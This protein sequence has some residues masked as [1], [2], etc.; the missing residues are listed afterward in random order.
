[1][2][3]SL[4]SLTLPET[5]KNSLGLLLSEPHDHSYA[6][7]SD[8]ESPRLSWA[9]KGKGKA[10]TEFMNV[11]SD[12][13]VLILL[14]DGVEHILQ[15]SYVGLMQDVMDAEFGDGFGDYNDDLEDPNLAGDKEQQPSASTS[16]PTTT[17]DIHKQDWDDQQQE[18]AD[19]WS[20]AHS[21]EVL[22]SYENEMVLCH[23]EPPNI[24]GLLEHMTSRDQLPPLDPEHLKLFESNPDLLALLRALVRSPVTV[25]PD[26]WESIL[27]E[28]DDNIDNSN[29]S[30]YGRVYMRFYYEEHVSS[31]LEAI[32]LYCEKFP[33]D[34][35]RTVPLQHALEELLTC[36]YTGPVW[37]VYTGVTCAGSVSHRLKED[38][39]KSGQTQYLNFF[40]RITWSER[41][42][43]MANF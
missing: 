23:L 28:C 5:T 25:N 37:H 39:Q 34:V 22:E 14:D 8:D 32:A 12:L 15:S 18:E 43:A 7:S 17:A 19:V 21:Q 33:G 4:L 13:P 29:N 40:Q 30:N 6:D 27:V 9:A 20:Q 35:H 16:K 31:A 36:G 24:A 42:V 3:T 41:H 38:E 2:D 26:D 10:A 1:M 11:D